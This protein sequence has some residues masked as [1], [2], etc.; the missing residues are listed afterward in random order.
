MFETTTRERTSSSSKAVKEPITEFFD[1]LAQCS[2]TKNNA[3]LSAHLQSPPTALEDLT[4]GKMTRISASFTHP[5]SRPAS[6][7]S[8]LLHCSL[9]AR[10]ADLA[11]AAFAQQPI[12][13][14]HLFTT[15]LGLRFAVHRSD[16]VR[17]NATSL[18]GEIV[19]LRRR[20]IAPVVF[21]TVCCRMAFRLSQM[22]SSLFVSLP[23]L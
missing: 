3:R 18:A 11:A 17:P 15:D 21:S 2:S 22:G 7:K 10:L 8:C 13:P 19:S 4:G 5:L 23:V 12:A 16:R 1:P 9:V 20:S 14:A 6:A